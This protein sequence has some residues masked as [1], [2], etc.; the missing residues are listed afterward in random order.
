MRRAALRSV[1]SFLLL[2]GTLSA[3]VAGPEVVAAPTLEQPN[4]ILITTDDQSVADL[5][6]MSYTRQFL[7]GGGV[8]FRDAIS[9]YPLCCPARATLMTGQHAHNHGVLANKPPAGGYE[10]LRPLNDRTLPV[11]LQNAGYRTTFTGKYLNTYG[12]D[13]MTEVPAGWDN[14]HAMVRGVYD[15][16]SA[17]VNENG[18]VVDHTG[19][20]QTDIT[21]DVTEEAIRV[22]ADTGQPF[23]VWQSNLAPHGACTLD[24]DGCTWGPPVPASRDKGTFDGLRLYSERLPSFNERVVVEKPARIKHRKRMSDRV[25]ARLRNWNE[26]SVESLQAVDRNVRDTVQL[27]DSLGELDNTLIVFTSDNGYLLGQHRWRGKVLGYEGSLRIPLLMRGPGVPEGKVVEDQV[28]LVD[29]PATFAAAARAVPLM[30]LDGLSLLDVA[31]GKRSGYDAL[32]IE[33]GPAYPNIPDDQYLY[34]G[35][36]TPRYTYMEHPVSGERELY[37]RALDPHQLVNVAY[38]PTHRTTRGAL[39]EMLRTLSTCAGQTCHQ[40]TGVVPDPEPAQGPVHPDELGSLRGARQVVTVT[41]PRWTAKR[42]IAVAWQKRGR[43]WRKVRGP[44]KV[45]LGADGM[46]SARR[47]VAGTT[48]A[49]VHRVASALGRRPAPTTALRYRR[50]DANDRWPHDRRSEQTYNVLQPFRSPEATWRAR[51]EV[52]FAAHEGSFERGLIMDFNRAR[53]TYWSREQRQRM[54]RTPANV[55]QGSFLVHT[56]PRVGRMGWLSMPTRDLT[57]LM[58]WAK[59]ADQGTSLVVGTP[60][61]LRNNL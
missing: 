43:T 47:R 54:A 41:A 61:Y 36:R 46:S 18:T 42:G 25:V 8:T 37:D 2:A 22:G 34:R 6:H 49:G 50:L 26:A 60:R 23:F 16:N 20:Y 58:R 14:W 5:K 35:V 38:R 19:E 33:A 52:L 27:L 57:W 40:V 24:D 10:S 21:Q 9:P 59:P 45:V 29:V 53:R 7:G 28:S 11:W 44:V 4:I 3:T 56:G 55:R 39:K 31:Q 13:D 12:H 17:K 15:F 48:P 1:T 51:S 30:T 32:A